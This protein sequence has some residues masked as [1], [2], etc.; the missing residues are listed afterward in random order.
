MHIALSANF[1]F[2]PVSEWFVSLPVFSN[3][4]VTYP[5]ITNLISGILWRIGFS[6]PLSFL[7]PSLLTTGLMLV[8][9]YETFR[10]FLHSKKKTIL[11]ATVFLCSGGLGFFRVLFDKGLS[12]LLDSTQ[13]M[14]QI[15]LYKLEMNSVIPSM[16]VPQRAFLL[17]FPV[18][19]LIMA[20]LYKEFLAQSNKQHT[21][22][23]VGAGIL[24][25][26][27]PIIHTHTYLVIVFFS[28]WIGIVRIQKLRQWMWY[29]IPATILSFVVYILFLHKGIAAQNFFTLHIGWLAG[30]SLKSWV[31]FWLQN[32]GIFLPLALIG[33]VRLYMQQK[34]DIVWVVSFFWFLFALANVVQFQPQQWDNT[35][36]FAWVYFGLS[37]PVVWAMSW[38]AS[39]GKRPFAWLVFLSL[40]GILCVSGAVDLMHNLDFQRK[41][42]EMLS[43]EQVQLGEYVRLH[44]MPDAVFLSRPIVSNPVSMIGGRS[45][46]LGYP[47]WAFSYGL[48][49]STREQNITKVFR[50]D[51]SLNT[52]REQEKIDYIYIEKNEKETGWISE[53]RNLEN[54]FENDA[55]TIYAIR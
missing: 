41:T 37:I 38:I 4:P 11:A 21:M 1:A 22:R 53:N 18:G 14:T 3:A 25:G 6:L 39:Y 42:F 20:I 29:V 8:L 52:L 26:L 27:L 9:L 12:G 45:V 44:T 51:L 48:D 17:G 28:A 32:W 49:Y 19:L 47:G 46:Y 10:V 34:R 7:L 31:S 33:T 24:A 36:M 15:E 40:T 55:G 54:V 43:A 23:L 30:D 35:K 13:S 16:F 2:R 5:F 50:S